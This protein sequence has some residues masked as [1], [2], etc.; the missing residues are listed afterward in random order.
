MLTVTQMIPIY[1]L[2]LMMMVLAMDKHSL[3]FLLLLDV[4]MYFIISLHGLLFL[5][6]CRSSFPLGT[7]K[8]NITYENENSE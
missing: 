3:S 4:F 1:L 8:I 7:I 5:Q 2:G 6:G